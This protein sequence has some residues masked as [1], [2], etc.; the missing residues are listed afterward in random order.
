MYNVHPHNTYAYMYMYIHVNICTY[1]S[2][3][4]T[5]V[6]RKHTC[7][8]AINHQC[9]LW[10]IVTGVTFTIVGSYEHKKEWRTTQE[11]P[12]QERYM[13]IYTHM[14]DGYVTYTMYNMKNTKVYIHV[15]THVHV[16]VCSYSNG[17]ESISTHGLIVAS[18]L[19][20]SQQV[21]HRAL[22]EWNSTHKLQSNYWKCLFTSLTFVQ[23]T[24]DFST[25][26]I[27]LFLHLLHYYVYVKHA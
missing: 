14:H 18:V 6:S 1:S 4:Y 24:R 12:L 13:Y 15:C 10:N 5:N 27:I 26:T 17:Q 21:I 9:Y 11:F 20:I 19:N 25:F 8:R 7:I 3:A 22:E 23:I 2:I 16:H